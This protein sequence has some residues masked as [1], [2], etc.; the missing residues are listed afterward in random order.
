MENKNQENMSLS[1]ELP[2][3]DWD[4]VQDITEECPGVFYLSVNREDSIVL[5]ELYAVQPSAVPEIISEEAAVYGK[6]IDGVYFFEYDLVKSGWDLVKYEIMRCRYKHGVPFDETASLYSTAVFSADQY[7][8]YFGET[9]PPRCTPWG[10]VVRCKK[11]ADGVFFLETD[12]CEWL[13]ALSFPV[14]SAGISENARQFG[15][16]HEAD[17][18]MGQEEAEYL[19]FQ[20]DKCAPAIFELLQNKKYDGIRK[21]IYSQEVLETA[22]YIQTPAYAI[23]KNLSENSMPA[24]ITELLKT[25]T[26]K[27]TDLLSGQVSKH[28]IRFNPDIVDKE[29]LILSK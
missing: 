5:R 28:F 19:Y 7:P 26:E 27:D 9:I 13:L 3:A 25:G 12:K 10:L 21:F 16:L 11:A 15:S 24:Y 6:K 18:R 8:E 20:R 23:T 4:D 14:W 1:F 22:L 17:K 2:D 29:L